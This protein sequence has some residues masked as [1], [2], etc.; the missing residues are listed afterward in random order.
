MPLLTLH[1]SRLNN[2]ASVNAYL[3]TAWT[4]GGVIR[5]EAELNPERTMLETEFSNNKAYADATFRAVQPLNIRLVPVQVGTLVL[6]SQTDANVLDMLAWTRQVFPT[7]QIDVTHQAGPLVANYNYLFPVPFNGTCGPGWNALL[8]D[9]AVIANDWD[10]RPQN[11]VVFGVIDP[12]VPP[13]GGNG[14]GAM[15]QGV[16]GGIIG[17]NVGELL[18]HEMGHNFDRMHVNCG[19]PAGAHFDAVPPNPAVP[20][21][22][23]ARVRPG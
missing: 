1:Q 22:W 3:P 6:N 15:D 16:S 8:G 4:E 14:C 13:G 17:V 10:D 11:A 12:G 2:I 19:L 21:R 9:L 7:H 20:A 18:T 5:L 23:S